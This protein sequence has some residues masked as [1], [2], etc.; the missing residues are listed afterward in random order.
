MTLALALLAGLLLATPAVSAA[1]AAAAKRSR[2][3]PANHALRVFLDCDRGCDFDFL[4]RTVTYVNYVRDP[5]DAL[6]HVLVTSRGTGSGSERTLQ[7]MG[8]GAFEGVDQRLL[9]ASSQTDT[10]DE[11][12]RGFARIFQ[13]GLVRYVLE[14][15]LAAGLEISYRVRE[16]DGATAVAAAVASDD[17]WN[18]WIFRARANGSFSG[19][20]QRDEQ[21]LD[22]SFTAG[23]TTERWRIGTGIS[24]SYRE[25]DF[26][27]DDGST[28]ND[29]TRSSGAS[30][31]GVRALG[32]H[33]G[34]GFGASARRSTFLNLDQSF[35]A[36][37]AIEYNLY[38]YAESSERQLTFTY[39]LG[40]NELDYEQ[41]TL[42]GELGE[43]L[44][45]Q[46]VLV[47]YDANRPWGEGSL[48][49]RLSHFLEDVELNR[50]ELGGRLDY[51]IFRGLSVS[52]NARAER[53]R[54][55]VFLPRS[56][57]T[58]EEVLL[59]IRALETDFQFRA[60]VGFSY[61]FGSI[62]NN[63]VNSRLTG[64]SGNFHR[65]SF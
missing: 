53:A 65:L 19:E 3:E 54:D 24:A 29:T 58:E 7:F 57:A 20:D 30:G 21:Y 47:S 41:E 43:S 16:D 52:V 15:P 18:F 62:Y 5:D 38:D 11:E 63:V 45:D 10:E 4:R 12:R 17:P 48:E 33:W 42:S 22:G 64:S 1:P 25:R 51:R 49:L 46:G 26:E 27:F 44:A 32:P 14:T 35:R 39:F 23:R 8:L 9:Y 60:G 56:G 31:V 6:V 36:A 55:L 37:G 34:V 61:T 40:V 59:G 13:L 28:F 50:V 2:A